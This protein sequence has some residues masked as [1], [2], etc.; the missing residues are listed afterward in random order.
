MQIESPSEFA[1]LDELVRSSIHQVGG[2]RETPTF[3][4]DA[5][6]KYL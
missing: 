5:W 1:A 3:A 6:C 4:A 2:K